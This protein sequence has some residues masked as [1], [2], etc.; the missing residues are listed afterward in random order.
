MVHG[1]ADGERIVAFGRVGKPLKQG[2]FPAVWDLD[3]RSGRM[4]TLPPCNG[5]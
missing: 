4:A 3:R 2:C 1:G 5:F